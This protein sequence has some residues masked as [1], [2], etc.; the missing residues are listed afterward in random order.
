VTDKLAYIRDKSIPKIC[1]RNL[2]IT[3]EMKQPI[4][5]YYQLDNFYQN[6]RRY[7]K[8]RNDAQLRDKSKA[9]D[10]SNCDPEATVDGK[11]IVP[12]GL[13]AWS[14][15]N[16]TYNLVRNNENLTVD[17]K[18]ISWKSDR[19]HKFGSDVF[20]TNFQKGPLQGGKILNSSM[21]TPSLRSRSSQLASQFLLQNG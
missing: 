17:K 14:L 8:S 16:D 20:P 5:V 19:E 10:T 6:H 11:P 21:P 13:I 12:C 1:T 3:K 7:V 15:F 4:F 2:T 9:S 18:D